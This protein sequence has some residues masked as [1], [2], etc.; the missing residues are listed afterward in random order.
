[1]ITLL[2][3]SKKSYSTSITSVNRSGALSSYEFKSIFSGHDSESIYSLKA[4][5]ELYDGDSKYIRITTVSGSNQ[6]Q[7]NAN[8]LLNRIREQSVG[9]GTLFD[10]NQGLRTGADKLSP[11]HIRTYSLGNSYKKGEGIFI[12]SKDEIRKLNLN[13]FENSLIKPLFKNSDIQKYVAAKSTN[14]RLIDIFWPN[15]RGMDVSKIPNLMKHF[16]RF[17]A[18]L[19]GRNE[20]AN[21]IDKAIAKGLYY[22]GSVRRKMNFGSAKII[23]PQRSKENV[24]AYNDSD[25]Y[26]SADVY[27][28]SNP[29]EEITLKAILPILN[30]KLIFFWLYHRGKRKGEMLELYQVP[31]S[32]IPISK[33]LKKRIALFEDKA[34]QGI[35]FSSRG[36]LNQMFLSEVDHLVYRLYD[37]TYN[38]VK[39]ID[40]EVSLSKKEYEAIKLE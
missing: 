29:T 14:Y 23:S 30:S 15:D 11:K 40:P 3:K 28:I 31:L 36:Q 37:L 35:D 25:W 39:L 26:A 2:T 9:L 5:N 13:S 21:G 33:R 10:V 6:L 16:E 8:S 18:V 7:S 17:R 20:N 32:E 34:N 4:K 12:L 19:E 27:F 22:F 38:E 24:F 1:M